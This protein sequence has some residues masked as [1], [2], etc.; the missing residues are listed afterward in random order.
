M[1]AV[2]EHGILNHINDLLTCS[3]WSHMNRVVLHLPKR[4]H[5]PPSGTD[6]PRNDVNATIVDARRQKRKKKIT[7]WCA[8]NKIWKL[9]SCFTKKALEYV[10]VVF[11]RDSESGLGIK[12]GHRQP[13]YQRKP[14]LT[15]IANPAV[16]DVWWAKRCH[17]LYSGDLLGKQPPFWS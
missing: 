6:S 9:G 16:L 10:C 7:P 4:P 3:Q 14:H 17:L 8:N 13:K 11:H 15:S 5:L 1:Q 2:A 12:I